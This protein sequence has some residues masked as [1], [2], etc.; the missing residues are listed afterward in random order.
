[1]LWLGAQTLRQVKII[2]KNNFVEY[3]E[4]RFK[5]WTSFRQTIRPHICFENY[6]HAISYLLNYS[7]GRGARSGTVTIGDSGSLSPPV[8]P[9]CEVVNTAS[10]EIAVFVVLVLLAVISRAS[11]VSVS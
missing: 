5:S 6:D 10:L 2:D 11:P 1:M 7:H 4:P 3:I 8:P 9:E